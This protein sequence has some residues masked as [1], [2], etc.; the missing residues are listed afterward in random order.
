MVSLIPATVLVGPFDWKQRIFVVKH[1]TGKCCTTSDR[2]RAR[3]SALGVVLRV[4]HS[5]PI[6]SVHIPLAVPII[7]AAWVVHIYIC[8]DHYHQAKRKKEHQ[9]LRHKFPPF[10]RRGLDE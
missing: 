10:H 2:S 6:V 4:E 9:A 7:G 5:V 3:I 1:S 8:L